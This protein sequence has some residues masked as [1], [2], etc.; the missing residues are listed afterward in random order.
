[1]T[2][3]PRH[4]VGIALFERLRRSSSCSL[5]RQQGHPR[6]RL[7]L[8]RALPRIV[9]SARGHGHGD[10]RRREVRL[11]VEVGLGGCAAEALLR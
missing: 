10:G 1:M 9:L 6:Q 8:R 3:W 2:R 4:P 11:E 5:E 7:V